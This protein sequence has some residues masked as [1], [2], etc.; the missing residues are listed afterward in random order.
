MSV[1]ETPSLIANT[2]RKTNSIDT[3]FKLELTDS[4]SSQ[5][6]CVCLCLDETAVLGSPPPFLLSERC[7]CNWSQIVCLRCQKRFISFLSFRQALYR[8]QMEKAQQGSS[9]F[10]RKCN[11]IMSL[12]PTKKLHKAAG[13]QTSTFSCG[14][15]G[16][17][18]ACARERENKSFSL[19]LSLFVA[20][21]FLRVICLLVCL[22]AHQ[23]LFAC[24][25]VKKAYYPCTFQTLCHG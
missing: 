3:V 5:C 19:S 14:Q 22:F 12:T 23:C 7:P 21:E 9:L 24:L 16:R 15:M 6:V 10:F 18:K 1:S 2:H 8:F 4:I 25:S 13:L 11:A 17:V 20:A